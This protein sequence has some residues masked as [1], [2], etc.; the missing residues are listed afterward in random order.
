MASSKS[1]QQT[2]ASTTQTDQRV[3]I[4]GDV[5]EGSIA[6][7]SGSGNSIVLNDVSAEI[8]KA[9]LATGDNAV[10]KNTTLV[11]AVFDD[12]ASLLA[13]IVKTNSDQTRASQDANA[14]LA[15]QLVD[16]TTQAVKDNSA[17]AANTLAGDV[18]KYGALV[19]L[20]GAVGIAVI[21]SKKN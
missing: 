5:G 20:A 21:N 17:G 12:G 11:S 2:Q 10:N 4:G 18:I 3:G 19:A 7:V 1:S 8:A 13:Q 9:A 14:A 6:G 15:A 16:K